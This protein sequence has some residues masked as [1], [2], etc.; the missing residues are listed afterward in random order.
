MGSILRSLKELLPSGVTA[1]VRVKVIRSGQFELPEKSQLI[2][3]FYWISSS[4]V[5]LEEVAVN[6]QH[7][8][9]IQSEEE[10][11]DLKFIIAKCPQEKLPYTFKER[12]GL[13]NL[14][15]QY[16]A[17]KVKHFSIFGIKSSR[18][19][20]VRCAAFKYYKQRTT[21]CIPANTDFHF[22][23]V[24]NLPPETMV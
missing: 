10:Y 12:E 13:F 7:C 19:T 15:T 4:E 2:S 16:A 3:A 23:L 1:T 6:I 11:S 20:K 17:I 9:Y 8:A 14:D 18:K 21:T 22:V 5:F 24:R